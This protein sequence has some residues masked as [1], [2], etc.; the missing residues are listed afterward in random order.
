MCFRGLIALLI[1]IVAKQNDLYAKKIVRLKT[2][3]ATYP[4]IV[5]WPRSFEINNAKACI[6]TI[7]ESLH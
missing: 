6:L 7:S 2:G 5:R 1:V 3:V 4:P